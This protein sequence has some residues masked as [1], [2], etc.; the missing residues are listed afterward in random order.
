MVWRRQS[1]KS[2]KPSSKEEGGRVYVIDARGRRPFMRGIMV[3]SLTARGIAFERAYETADRVRN[4]IRGRSEVRREELGE[5]VVEF[6]GEDSA[7]LPTS[8]VALPE[9][10]EVGGDHRAVPFS[11]GVLSQSLLAASIDPTDAF[12][13]AREIELS[14]HRLGTSRVTRAQ[15]RKIAHEALLERFDRVTAERFLAWR[16]YQEPSKPVIVLLGGTTGVGKTSIALE[17]ALRLGIRRVLSTDSIRQVMRIMLSQDLAPA[18]HASSFDAHRS[19]GLDDEG[20]SRVVEGFQQQTAIVSVGVRA[21]LDR[22]IEEHT[23]LVLDGVSIVPGQIDL[24]SYAANAHVISLLIGRLDE[25]AFLGHFRGR[26]TEAPRRGMKRYRQNFDSILEIQN[27]LLELADQHDV[28]IVDNRSVESSVPLV[29]RH[30][31]EF[32]RD[33]GDPTD[34]ELPYAPD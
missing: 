9:T 8:S 27:H 18:L 20:V 13:V 23:S 29:I 10:I 15:L 22:A 6:S 26:G 1:E 19:L 12:E 5:L 14:L 17:V 32:L 4:A 2:P 24:D 30:V 31:V 11:K 33:L 25:Q 28:P 16:E 21:M 7:S 34:P 3:H